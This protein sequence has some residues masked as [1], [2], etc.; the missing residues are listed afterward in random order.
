[1]KE[2]HLGVNHV[3]ADINRS[4]WIVRGRSAVKRIVDACI[5]CRFW[6]VAPGRQKMA[7]L[8]PERLNITKPFSSI[9]TDLM[10]PITI[11]IGRNRVKRYICIFNC[12]ATRGVHLEV[13]PSQ[14]VDAFLQAFRR[15]CNRRNVMPTKIYSDNGGN[16]V[17]ARGRLSGQVTWHLNPPR[18]SHQGGFYESFL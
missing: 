7:N 8:P 15:F 18:A 17:A 4:Y 2:G 13:V 11:T 9:G 16:F 14:D 5:S 3:L 10:G 6:K 1:M 12:L